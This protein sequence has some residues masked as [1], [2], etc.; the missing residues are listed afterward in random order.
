MEFG[1]QFFFGHS[2]VVVVVVGVVIFPGL[3][4]LPLKWFDVTVNA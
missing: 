2:V 1:G 4:G 3:F